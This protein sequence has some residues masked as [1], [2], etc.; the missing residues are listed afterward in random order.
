MHGLVSDE[1][2]QYKKGHG[3]TFNEN[4]DSAKQE[5]EVISYFAPD[6]VV[7]GYGEDFLSDFNN[8]NKTKLIYTPVEHFG[9]LLILQKN[10]GK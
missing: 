4:S 1:V 6:Y 10:F 2:L 7:T 5:A 3:L 8:I 9:Q